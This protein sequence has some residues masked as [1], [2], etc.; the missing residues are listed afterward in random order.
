VDATIAAEFVS[1]KPRRLLELARVGI[2]PGHPIGQ[3][4]R[5]VWRFRLS[6][7]AAAVSSQVNSGPA[8][9]G[10]QKAGPQSISPPEVW[11]RAV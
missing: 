8:V 2:F 11:W 7:L 4:P 6:E 3:G 10:G 5:K 1:L 9:P